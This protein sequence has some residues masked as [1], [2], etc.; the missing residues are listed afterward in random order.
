MRVRLIECG[1]E[2]VKKIEMA[3]PCIIVYSM[4]SLLH[5]GGATL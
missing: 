3:H 2:G 5:S 4:A 1:E